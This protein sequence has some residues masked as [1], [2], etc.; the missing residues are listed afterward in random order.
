MP[1][2]TPSRDAGFTLTETLVAT[3][4]VTG[5]LLG[6][7]SLFASGA[8]LQL[9]ATTGSTSV[10]RVVAQIEWL[11]S[12]PV[13]APQR[14]DGG[15]LT[16]NVANHFLQT[17]QA[18]IRWTVANGPACGPAAWSGPVAVNECAKQITMVAVPVNAQGPTVQVQAM[19]WR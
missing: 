8:R 19:L 16:A 12:L 1:R 17:G 11:R 5:G 14:A 6:V 10:A 15:S 13:G 18:T 3:L 7:A 9:N 2:P 4:I